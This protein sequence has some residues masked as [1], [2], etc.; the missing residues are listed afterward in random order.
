MQKGI[1]KGS[2]KAASQNTNAGKNSVATM[3]NDSAKKNIAGPVIIQQTVP[4]PVQSV[5]KS[6]PISSVQSANESP[7][8]VRNPDSPIR[9]NAN[10]L[11]STT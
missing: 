2:I 11:M 5:P 8:I 9:I 1:N 10:I 6:S 4:Q 7:Y 3:V